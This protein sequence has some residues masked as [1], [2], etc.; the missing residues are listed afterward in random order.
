[1]KNDQEIK[2]EKDRLLQDR[3]NQNEQ[4]TEHEDSFEKNQ[5]KE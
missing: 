5:Q 2:R 4:R 1:M 3:S